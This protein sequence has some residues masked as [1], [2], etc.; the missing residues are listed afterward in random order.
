MKYYG[1]TQMHCGHE[2]RWIFDEN[3]AKD[4]IDKNGEEILWPMGGS[5]VSATFIKELK[6][7]KD[8]IQFLEAPGDGPD[9]EDPM[10]VDLAEYLVTVSCDSNSCTK[11]F[12]DNLG[13]DVDAL[14][15][16]DDYLN[17]HTKAQQII[18]Q[19]KATGYSNFDYKNPF[20]GENKDMTYSE[21]EALLIN[22]LNNDSSLDSLGTM[23]IYIYTDYNPGTR[24]A[25]SNVH[26]HGVYKSN[27]EAVEKYLELIANEN[28]L[29]GDDEDF[30][31]LYDNDGWHQFYPDGSERVHITI[32]KLKKDSKFEL[33][34]LD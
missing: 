16:H 24:K 6:G 34:G 33:Y 22:Q 10:L 25:T 19:L 3:E 7:D 8:I 13:L 27:T 28:A 31:T 32:I 2:Y 18:M 14:T 23:V 12:I 5:N 29:F 17:R 20:Y 15:Q 11:E 9:V 26:L 4:Y 30:I 21:L 1:V